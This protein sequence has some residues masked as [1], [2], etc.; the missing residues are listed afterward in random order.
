ML[1]LYQVNN[2]GSLE[3]DLRTVIGDTGAAQLIYWSY[4][5][6]PGLEEHLPVLASVLSVTGRWSD[7]GIEHGNGEA[8]EDVNGQTIDDNDPTCDDLPADT[9]PD[10]AASCKT[11]A[12]VTCSSTT[13]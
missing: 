7:D 12:L 2:D 13:T 5:C 11:C 6:G 4:P 8:Y 10:S 1:F 9:L 3:D